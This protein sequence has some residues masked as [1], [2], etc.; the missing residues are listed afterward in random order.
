MI[1]VTGGTG[2][3]GSHLLYELCIKHE[4]IIALGRVKSNKNHLL[5]LFGYYSAEPQKLFKKILWRDADLLNYKTLVKALQGV[6]QI[7]HCAGKISFNDNQKENIFKLNIKGTSNIVNAAIEN[8]VEKLIFVSSTSAYGKSDRNIIINEN[9]NWNWVTYNSSYSLSKYK[10]ETEVW[11]GSAKGLKIV[12]VNPSIVIG[13]GFWDRGFG[14][15]FNEINKGLLF[16]PLGA[17]GFV[18][19]RDLVRIMIILMNK[20]ISGDQFIINSENKTYKE[21]FSLIANSL[22]KSS[23]FIPAF[24]VFTNIIWRIGKIFSSFTGKEPFLTK[25]NLTSSQSTNYFTNKKIVD[26]TGITFTPIKDSINFIAEKLVLDNLHISHRNINSKP[27][28]TYLLYSWLY[29]YFFNIDHRR[30]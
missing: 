11:K 12:I 29:S 10:A 27:Q 19:V 17:T 14:K 8:K 3:I 9:I 22:N 16:Y 2:L 23:H 25:E 30:G 24:P 5:K 26:S 18:D 20:N 13:P 21:M 28:K 7:Y 15:L 6:S 4:K 1:L